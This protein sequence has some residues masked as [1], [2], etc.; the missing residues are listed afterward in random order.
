MVKK[1]ATQTQK[2]TEHHK[3]FGII[4][5][6]K[7]GK[8]NINRLRIFEYAINRHTLYATHVYTRKSTHTIGK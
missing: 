7:Y 8:P 4:A 2:A 5:K 6:I 1:I 3:T